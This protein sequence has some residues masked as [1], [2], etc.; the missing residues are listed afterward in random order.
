MKLL[1][2]KVSINQG[3]VY[4]RPEGEAAVCWARLGSAS[5]DEVTLS[6]I[7]LMIEVEGRVRS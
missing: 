6:L 7:P 2:R 4:A 3:P 1:H 5:M